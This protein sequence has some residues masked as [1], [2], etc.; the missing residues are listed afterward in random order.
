MVNRP[1]RLPAGHSG[2]VRSEP[3]PPPIVMKAVPEPGP[4]ARQQPPPPPILADPVPDLI[5][6]AAEVMSQPPPHPSARTALVRAN[7]P[8]RPLT[9]RPSFDRESRMRYFW[10]GFI[11]TA[12]GLGGPL[13][14]IG[15][16]CL[17][18]P[19]IPP[20]GP[21]R[22]GYVVG[23]ERW[24]ALQA[25]K[26]SIEPR[27][28]SPAG[29]DWHWE[30][31]QSRPFSPGTDWPGRV[32]SPAGSKCRAWT[33]SGIIDAP[34]A[35]GVKVRYRWEVIEALDEN[36]DEFFAVRVR[37]DD[38][39]IWQDETIWEFDPATTTIRWRLSR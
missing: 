15:F 39:T 28:L 1:N 13:C 4:W 6:W 16:V 36:R 32:F 35:F 31:I 22:S 12:I 7:S 17:I 8:S 5:R 24:T 25:A 29:T 10:R 30:S 37:V 14:L 18:I 33:V 26:M 9:I 3:S 21:T 34:N 20:A 23:G 27:L 11:W 38:E 2:E 19:L